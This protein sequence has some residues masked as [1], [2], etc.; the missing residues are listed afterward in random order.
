MEFSFWKW[1]AGDPQR[2]ALVAPG[3]EET[4][5]GALLARSNQLARALRERCEPGQMVAC[6][7]KNEPATYELALAVFQAGLFLVPVNWHLVAEEIAF[8]L[9]DCGA[10]MFVCSPEFAEVAA[11]AA[12]RA[13]LP[14]DARLCTGVSLMAVGQAAMA[15]FAEF[16]A[17]LPTD[18]PEER[19]AGGIMTYTSGTTGRPRGVHRP[20]PPVP[21]EPVVTGF[22]MFLM[23]FGITPNDGVHIV[24]APLYHTAVLYFSLNNL[25]LG[26]AVVLTDRWTPEGFLD[27]VQR[28]RV[29]NS[30][31]VPTHFTRLLNYL[32]ADP[33][34]R[35][36]YDVSS[37][38]QI[39]H[40]AA[41]C[42]ESVKRRMLEWWGPIIWEYYAATEGGGTVASAQE[43]L[44]RPGT[45]GKAWQTA[46]IAIFDDE[47]HR[48]APGEVGTVYIKMAQSFRYHRDEQKTGKAYRTDGYF[49]VGDMGYLD[50]EGYLF[51]CDRKADMIIS[52]GVNIYPAEIEGVLI[53]HPNVADVAVFGVPD[54]DW[55]EQ[56]KAVIEPM[57]A[58]PGPALAQAILEWTRDRLGGYKRPRSIDFVEELPREP[59]GKLKKR[60]LRDPYWEGRDRAI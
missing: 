21:P 37:L 7:L 56:V 10:K 14:A 11:E 33:G 16:G 27:R 47:G 43:W 15:P 34:A 20:L 22:A 44:E 54:D 29:T 28:Y 23:L 50:A 52:G 35:E 40:G 13:G 60:L 59:N 26:N 49:T 38:R 18:P 53:E 51:L 55:G 8:I 17:G 46:E 32:D 5:A 57:G 24:A 48:L 31:M 3:G 25:H 9:E 58:E 30:H 36:R 2:L 1:A 45:V 4:S 6:L 19:L 42:P 12:D 41:P 39:V